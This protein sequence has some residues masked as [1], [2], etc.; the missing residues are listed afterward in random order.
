MT[1]CI[2]TTPSVTDQD[3]DADAK[4]QSA[5]EEK[6]TMPVSPNVWGEEEE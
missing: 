1:E 3:H 6:E 5:F 2:L 4:E